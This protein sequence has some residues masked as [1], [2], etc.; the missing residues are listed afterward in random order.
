MADSIGIAVDTVRDITGPVGDVFSTLSTVQDICDGTSIALGAASIIPGAAAVTGPIIGV[1]EAIRPTLGE[2]I[3]F[4]STVLD[5]MNTA[6]Q[7]MEELDAA[8]SGDFEQ[9]ASDAMA[10]AQKAMSDGES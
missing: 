9:F 1:Y 3:D 6:I 7:V 4:G 5:F 2:V 8:I 10:M